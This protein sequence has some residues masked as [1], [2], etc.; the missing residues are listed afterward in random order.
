MNIINGVIQDSTIAGIK[1][2]A[3]ILTPK[4]VRNA[5]TLVPLNQPL[6]I[7]VH[8]TGNTDFSAGDEAHAAYAQSV[9]NA[10]QTYLSWHFTVDADSITQH[11]PLNEHGWHAG[12]GNGIGNMNGI[13][14]EI[15][16]NKDYPA[17]EANGI[18]LI[19]ALMEQFN[20]PLDRVQPHRKFSSVKKLCPWRILKSQATWESDW[21]A[22]QQ[23]I[24][25]TVTEAKNNVLTVTISGE[26]W[27]VRA[28]PSISADK[29]EWIDKETTYTSSKQVAGWYY[30]DQLEGWIVADAVKPTYATY[31]VKSGDGFW[32]I[33]QQQMGSGSKAAELAAFNGLTTSSVIKPGQVLRIPK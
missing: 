25:G 7:I 18:K 13:G 33:A 26:G 2:T 9:E 24:S 11:L 17:C 32:R 31:T 23:R 8:N 1:F 19:Q 27:N 10:D 22:F 3:K 15:A 5:R 30:L 28:E 21:K 20:I 29:K 16:E 6:H 14:I 4:G 12:D